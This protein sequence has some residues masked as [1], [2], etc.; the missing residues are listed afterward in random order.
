[1]NQNDRKR[2]EEA[3]NHIGAAQASIEMAKD[4]MQEIADG[5]REKFDNLTEGLQAS[6]RGQRYDENV[7]NIESL[8]SDLEDCGSNLEDLDFDGIEG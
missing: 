2:I 8:I 3:K 6:E 4:I 5:E 7:D 1:M